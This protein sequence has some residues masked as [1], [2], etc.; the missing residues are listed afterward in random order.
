M[1]RGQFIFLHDERSRRI[2]D[3]IIIPERGFSAGNVRS[4]MRAVCLKYGLPR[5]GF[6]LE[7]GK[8]FRHAALVS[9][10]VSWGEVKTSFAQRLG[11]EIH[12]TRPGNHK[13]KLAEGVGGILQGR[14]RKYPGWCGPNEMVYPIEATRKALADVEAKR[15]TP[16]AAGFYSLNQ[17]CSILSSECAAYNATPQ[18]SKVMGGAGVAVHLSPNDAWR[19]LAGGEPVV[20]LRESGA[21]YLLTHHMRMVNVRRTGIRFQLGKELYAYSGAATAHSEVVGQEVKFYFDPELP[22]VAFLETV[23][24]RI[25][26]VERQ[27]LMP[28]HAASESDWKHRDATVEAHNRGLKALVSN[29]PWDFLP[30]VRSNVLADETAK[31]GAEMARGRAEAGT[32]KRKLVSGQGTARRLGIAAPASARMADAL[33]IVNQVIADRDAEN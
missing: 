31:R 20:G 24:G 23:N 6:V 1:T 13:G 33:D 15:L 12:H 22:D 30:A 29:L 16:E 28:A 5:K 25:L 18:D 19:N 11:I 26:T 27:K 17:W 9:G 2:L 4:L 14:L 8:V 7:N 32:R 3:F 21:E 10:A